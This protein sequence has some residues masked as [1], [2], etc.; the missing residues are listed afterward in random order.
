MV[1]TVK[2]REDNKNSRQWLALDGDGGVRAGWTHKGIDV[3]FLTGGP[4]GVHYHPLNFTYKL[5]I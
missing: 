2:K 3:V 5:H 4:I 1:K